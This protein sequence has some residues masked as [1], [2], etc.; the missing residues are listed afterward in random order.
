MMSGYAA[1]AKEGLDR[2]QMV[3]EH[4]KLVKKVAY[5][6]VGRLPDSVDVEDLISAGMIGLLTAV[7]RYEP[8][9]GAFAAFAEWRIKGA[10]LDELRGY[11]HLTRTQR[12]KASSAEKVR[13]QLEQEFGRDASVEEIAEASG[14]DVDEVSRALEAANGPVFI[15][16]DDLGI[17]R[18][19]I[20]DVLGQMNDRNGPPNPLQFAILSETKRRLVDVL[21]SLK[22][23]EQTILS[24]YYVEE[25][26]YREIGEIMELTESR[27]CQI[28]RET[29][30]RLCKRMRD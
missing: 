8:S 21:K 29:L 27:I 14:L 22:G 2:D 11:D 10:I 16:L 9:R 30:K 5:R 17:D 15:S 1:A 13:R 12:Q 6:I 28:V 3:R 20:Q 23:R 26:N 19:D 24:L 7:D 25:L 4:A 18:E